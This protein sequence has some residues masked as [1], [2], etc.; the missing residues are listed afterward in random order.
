MFLPL[1]KIRKDRV[2]FRN[3]GHNCNWTV[4]TR[5]QDSAY[6][7]ALGQTTSRTLSFPNLIATGHNFGR[8]QCSL[9]S[10]PLV[11]PCHYRGTMTLLIFSLWRNLSTLAP[12]VRHTGQGNA[13]EVAAPVSI[14]P[15]LPELASNLVAQ[16]LFDC[17]GDAPLNGI[18]E[19]LQTLRLYH[20]LHTYW[21]TI[22]IPVKRIT[23]SNSTPKLPPNRKATMLVI[24][25]S[26]AT[27]DRTQPRIS[28][29]Y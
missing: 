10:S 16:H 5:F 19:I 27:R 1:S 15:R 22:S 9:V 6:V 8:G 7:F 24:R 13:S 4:S 14:R 3:G 29:T 21:K 12:S 23:H 25:R 17:V 26:V 2:T 20:V 28:I 18:I 11:G